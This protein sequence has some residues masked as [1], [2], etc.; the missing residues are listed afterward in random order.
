MNVD[1]SNNR[2]LFFSQK[3][4]IDRNVID[5]LENYTLQEKAVFSYKAFDNKITNASQ[6]NSFTWWLGN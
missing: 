5:E 6:S 3:C 4:L 2:N 1:A